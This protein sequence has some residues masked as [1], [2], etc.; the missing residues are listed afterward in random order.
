MQAKRALTE[1][2]AFEEAV[3]TV[4]DM[5]ND[6]DTLVIVTADH[7]HTMTIAG[8][9]ERGNNILGNHYFHSKHNYF[10]YTVLK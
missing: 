5:T 6:Q 3:Q 1:T 2:L 7:S 9:P 4:L 8:Y 10:P